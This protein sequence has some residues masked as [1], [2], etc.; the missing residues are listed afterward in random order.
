MEVKISGHQFEYDITG[1]CL[2]FFPGESVRFVKRA[3]ESTWLSSRLVQTPKGLYAK[4][5][6]RKENQDYHCEKKVFGTA[7][8]DLLAAVKFTVYQVF[9]RA[10]GICPPWGILTGIKPTGIYRRILAEK[11][12]LATRQFLLKEYCMQPEKI[13]LL[14]QI[15][16]VMETVETDPAKEASLYVSIPFCPSRCTYCS[17]I[18]IAA[19]KSHHLMEPYLERLAEEIRDKCAVLKKHGLK[20]KSV[21]VGGGT[22]GILNVPQMERLL[23]TITECLEE[24][25]AE[26]TFELGRP[27]TVTEEKLALL[28]HFGVSR[29][30]INTQTTNDRILQSVGRK[31]TRTQYFDAV[32]L[33]RALNFDSINTDLIA[34]LPGENEESFAHSLEDVLAAGV[35]NITIHTLSIK[36][37]SRLHDSGEYFDPANDH[38]QRMLD[39]AYQRL[40]SLGY[41]PYYMYRQKNTVSN[42]ENIGFARPETIGLYNLY[43]MEDL[44]TVAACGAGASSKL[45]FAPN[46][47][48]ERII[49]MKYPYEYINE[50]ERIRRNTELLDQKLEERI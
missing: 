46:G 2:L 27:D 33:T 43:M 37:S 12:A 28:K 16:K 49:N 40:L 6:F 45:I 10:T 24:P 15:C 30:C 13:P 23:Q 9:H 8:D 35:D 19:E 32:S 26:F 4:A 48:I 47:R 17:F 38:V 18:S 22:P 3:R 31:H 20:I 21:Y 29:I 1:M 7:K 11:G 44:H 14:H 5:T 42:G 39:K 36:R 25:L 41:V 34:G 50:N